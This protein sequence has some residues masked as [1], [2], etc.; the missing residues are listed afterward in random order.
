MLVFDISPR[1]PD[2]NGDGNVDRFDIDALIGAIAAG[3]HDP[4]FDMTGDGRVDL[5]DRDQWLV[6]AGAINLPSGNPCL[7]GDSNLDG[8]VDGDDFLAWNISKFTAIAKWTFADFNAS[9]FVDGSDFLLWN[10]YK[11]QSA[12]TA[13][14][15]IPEPNTGLLFLALVTLH[16]NRKRERL[17]R[18]R[19]S[20]EE[21]ERG[22]RFLVN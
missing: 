17:W 10:T 1:T 11:F 22:S 19:L 16:A 2:L 18:K 13:A 15:L 6:D 7:L 8:T 20:A 5:D 3:N 21:N 4:S 14:D 9:G 12:D